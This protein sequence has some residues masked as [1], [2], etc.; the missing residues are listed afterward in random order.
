MKP[1]HEY[2]LREFV[3]LSVLVFAASFTAALASGSPLFTAIMSPFHIITLL[4]AVVLYNFLR[5]KPGRDCLNPLL[6]A[7]LIINILKIF[8]ASGVHILFKTETSP[9]LVLYF[10]ENIGM[11]SPEIPAAL[12]SIPA[13]IYFVTLPAACIGIYFIKSPRLKEIINPVL[14]EK[15][16]AAYILLFAS[17][18]CIFIIAGS[19]AGPASGEDNFRGINFSSAARKKHRD[20]TGFRSRYG[21][22]ITSSPDI[23]IFILEGVNAE[24][25][26][27]SGSRFLSDR[28]SVA[29]AK[30]FFVPTPHTSISIYSLLTGNYGDYRRRMEPGETETRNSLPSLLRERGYSTF[31]IYSGPT[32][33]EGL[34]SMLEGFSMSITEKEGLLSA[35]DPATGIHYKSFDWGVDDA[36]LIYAVSRTREKTTGPSLFF[37]GFSSTHSPYFNPEPGRFNRFDNETQQGRYKN[38]ID[39]ELYVIDRIIEMMSAR[40][41]NT[42]FVIV[43][44]HGESFGEEGYVK[45]SFS[46]YNTEISVPFIIRH[47]SFRSEVSVKSG[48]I[49]D[50]YPTIAD[51]LGLTLPAGVDGQS[52]FAED[53]RLSLFLSSWRDGAAKGFILDNKKWIYLRETDALLEMDCDDMNRRDIS[54]AR[55]KNDFI[56]FLDL[57]Y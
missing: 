16:P 4:T 50:V 15:F 19:T 30:N 36:A 7:F 9:G 11:L 28:S 24:S 56:R 8:T 39:Y 25:F 1:L 12:G 44:D 42:L 45:H 51:M 26:D 5:H 14:P 40:D 57:Q 18:T 38:C 3:P 41:S 32:H 22:N 21:Y 54:G 53:Y 13:A 34:D 37:V 48:T 23:V 2:E 55:G 29:R 52:M 31:F 20:T 33:F 35:I 6:Y 27:V 10:I 49:L 46:L 47:S 43:G 17:V